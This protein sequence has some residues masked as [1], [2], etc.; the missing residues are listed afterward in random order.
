MFP[1]GTAC[2]C[3]ETMIAQVLLERIVQRG[4][5]KEKSGNTNTL[6]PLYN[7][8]KN[9]PFVFNQNKTNF[10]SFDYILDLILVWFDFIIVTYFNMQCIIYKRKLRKSLNPNG[11]YYSMEYYKNGI[12]YYILK[13]SK[14]IKNKTCNQQ[15][16]VKMQS[17]VLLN[18]II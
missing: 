2:P 7:L 5:S 13:Y 11:E 3:E 10:L 18:K 16:G 1:C 12:K 8:E 17:Q 15:Y 6:Y 9:L 4:H 14:C